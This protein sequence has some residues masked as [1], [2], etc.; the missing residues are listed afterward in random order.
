MTNT[1]RAHQIFRWLVDVFPPP[2]STPKVRMRVVKKLPHE[3]KECLGVCVWNDKNEA[4]LWIKHGTKAL[5][6]P[7]VIHE[8]AHVLTD[9]KGISGGHGDAF[10]LTLGILEREFEATG[11]NDSRHY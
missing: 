4:M 5:M 1:R 8:Y 6:L 11:A 9:G 2:N 10:Y 7:V 3:F